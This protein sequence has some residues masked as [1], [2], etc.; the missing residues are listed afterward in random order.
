MGTNPTVRIQTNR[1]HVRFRPLRDGI[2]D[3]SLDLETFLDWWSA[4][5]PMIGVMALSPMKQPNE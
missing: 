2:H 1:T 4:P 5:T 3:K